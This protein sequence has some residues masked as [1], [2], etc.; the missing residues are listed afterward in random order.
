M[1]NALALPD[2]EIE[3]A[4]RSE[5]IDKSIDSIKIIAQPLEAYDRA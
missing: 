4:M 1:R 5:D 2:D 3:N